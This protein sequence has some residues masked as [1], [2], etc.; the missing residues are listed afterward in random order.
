MTHPDPLTRA[1]Q[2]R[3]D[4]AHHTDEQVIAALETIRDRS[5]DRAE[6]QSAREWLR[7]F[8]KKGAA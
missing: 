6:R 5:P 2:I 3:A 1:R 7:L 4:C 8:E